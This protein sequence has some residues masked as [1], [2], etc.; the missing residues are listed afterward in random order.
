[1][2]TGSNEPHQ[3]DIT[4]T[5]ASHATHDGGHERGDMGGRTGSTQPSARAGGGLGP[6]QVRDAEERARDAK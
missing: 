5:D 6:E 4:D 2:T 3:Q 1:M